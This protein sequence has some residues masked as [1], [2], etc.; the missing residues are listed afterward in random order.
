MAKHRLIDQDLTKIDRVFD[1]L[2]SFEAFST[3]VISVAWTIFD[4]NQGQ[5]FNLEMLE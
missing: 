4:R 3:T 2:D 1:F 5:V